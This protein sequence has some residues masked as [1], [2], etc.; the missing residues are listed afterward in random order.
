VFPPDD[1]RFRD[2]LIR[3][4]GAAEAGDR[5]GARR[6]F[7][8]ALLADPPESGRI[9]ALR[10][11]AD[12]AADAAE[13]RKYLEQLL[14]VD[15]TDGLARRDLA[16]LDGRLDPRDIV[17]PSRPGP[18][19]GVD[20]PG[21]TARIICRRCGSPHLA[22]APDGRSLVCQDC[23]A[24]QPIRGA[25]A[26]A[27]RDFAATM[28]TARG[29]K[30][31]VAMS[32]VACQGCGATFVAAAGQLSLI[33]PY[34]ASAYTIDHAESRQLLEPDAIVPFALSSDDA[35]RKVATW[36][37]ERGIDA[38]AGPPRGVFQPF[39]FLNF[40]GTLNWR[41]VSGRGGEPETLTGTYAIVQQRVVVPGLQSGAPVPEFGGDYLTASVPYD[42]RL[43]AGRPAALYDVPLDEADELARRSAI[44]IL[45][46][47]VADH[48]GPG[49]TDLSID[50]SGLAV[51]SFQLVAA[52]AWVCELRVHDV[53]VP[54]V[55]DGRTGALRADLPKHG[56]SGA[57][58]SVVGFLRRT[59]APDD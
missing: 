41:A 32:C 52:P 2:L 45:R 33:C 54:A 22:A 16:V 49:A 58:D 55:V 50:F 14:A 35:A 19:S 27:P 5:D 57:I 13:K 59:L 7:E 8:L 6:L 15:P 24:S 46:Q 20:V 1:D 11:L 23:H 36:I 9:R 51:D 21:V 43:L 28:W 3:G 37:E 48:V 26:L 17:D 42:S 12:N 30:T 29:H 53:R 31:P 10:A 56:V 18:S 34:C 4:I 47:D 40:I 38:V 39:W 44:A 25:P